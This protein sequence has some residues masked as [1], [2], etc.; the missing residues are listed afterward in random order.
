ML[1]ASGPREKASQLG[2]N[3]GTGAL[4]RSGSRRALDAVMSA[5]EKKQDWSSVLDR[6]SIQW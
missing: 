5:G 6:E 2:R 1:A 4:W 3:A